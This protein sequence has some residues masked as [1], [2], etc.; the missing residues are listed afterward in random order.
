[1]HKS[2]TR[3]FSVP[4]E[5]LIFPICLLIRIRLKKK[6]ISAMKSGHLGTY[7]LRRCSIH[8]LWHFRMDY[9]VHLQS[10]SAAGQV[11][12]HPYAFHRA[13]QRHVHPV[14]HHDGLCLP[15]PALPLDALMDSHY[16][17]R[18]FC[19]GSCHRCRCLRFWH[20]TF[21]TSFHPYTFSHK[22]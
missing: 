14:L 7:V 19:H 13:K 10:S 18:T 4:R 3:N 20:S 5:G 16:A 11:S 15:A 6:D 2:L 8:W 1:M 21:P 9:V 12:G 22:R 17:D